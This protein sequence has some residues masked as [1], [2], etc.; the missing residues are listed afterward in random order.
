[1]HVVPL[2]K[3]KEGAGV[4]WAQDQE[5][6]M[7]VAVIAVF[8]AR[9]GCPAWRLQLGRSFHCCMIDPGTCQRP[10][11][12]LHLSIKIGRNHRNLNVQKGASASRLAFWIQKL[13]VAAN[14][15]RPHSRAD[16]RTHLTDPP[17]AH[18]APAAR[19]RHPVLRRTHRITT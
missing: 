13:R 14:L 16:L 11:G 9:Q 3:L 10:H 7:S 2:T 18:S 8:C 6:M 19:N 17:A 5:Q 4:S 12:G 15:K 1:M